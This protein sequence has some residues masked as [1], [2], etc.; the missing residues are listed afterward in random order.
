MFTALSI[1]AN[2]RCML[3]SLLSK[4]CFSRQRHR[5]R[6]S[7]NTSS[8]SQTFQPVD[9]SVLFLCGKSACSSLLSVSQGNVHILSEQPCF[10]EWEAFSAF[11]VEYLFF[12]SFCCYFCFFSCIRSFCDSF[13]FFFIYLLLLLQ[14]AIATVFVLGAEYSIP[15]TYLPASL[16]PHPLLAQAGGI[17][18]SYS[19]KRV[20]CVFIMIPEPDIPFPMTHQ[21]YLPVHLLSTSFP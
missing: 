11:P 16:E 8:S 10:K 6:Q 7:A 19:S 20:T 12:I 4:C 3:F 9:Q 14:P 2:V 1:H 18:H 21:I 5:H 15:P 17:L 13:D